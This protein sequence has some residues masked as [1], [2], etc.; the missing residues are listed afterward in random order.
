MSDAGEEPAADRPLN[1]NN[2][3]VVDEQSL[4]AMPEVKSKT[5]FDRDKHDRARTHLTNLDDINATDVFRQYKRSWLTPFFG[6]NETEPYLLH[7]TVHPC[8]IFSNEVH[9]CLHSRGNDYGHCQPQV[10]AF[11]KC[12]VDFK[13]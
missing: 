13:L 5:V 8:R 4:R 10:A 7:T 12:L 2:D 9:R 6:A 3:D 11:Q 1:F